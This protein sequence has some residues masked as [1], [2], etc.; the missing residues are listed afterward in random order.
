[1]K[2][3]VAGAT[4]LIGR[5]V[6][7][8]LAALDTVEVDA[9]VRNDP[10]NLPPDCWVHAI[11]TENWGPTVVGIKPDVAICCLGTTWKKSGKSEA[12]FRAVDLDLV[13]AF[14]DAARTAGARH[15][16]AVSSVG[17]D[18]SA[19][20]FYLKTKGQAEDGL[21]ALNFPRLDILRPGLLTGGSRGDSR[22]GE[23]LG[24]IIS[25]LSDALMQ[26]G[27]RKYRS[28]PSAKVAQ[29][30]VTLTL[31]SGHGRHIHMNDAIRALAG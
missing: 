20:N 14:A 1:M 10:G 23:R 8:E 16:I 25:P 24:I 11:P 4:G 19:S 6:I 27:L 26:G 29:A 30:I 12:A 9:V 17:A 21:T 13:L 22:F 31:S 5:Q 18:N 28:I 15:M 2:V 7:E 3:I